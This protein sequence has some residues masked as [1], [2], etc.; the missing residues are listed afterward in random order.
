[1]PRS[2]S[3]KLHSETLMSARRSP[4]H[5]QNPSSGERRKTL[6][7][8]HHALSSHHYHRHIIICASYISS[9]DYN[10]FMVLQRHLKDHLCRKAPK[11]N[12][13]LLLLRVGGFHQLMSFMGAGCKLVEEPGLDGLWVTVYDKNSLSKMMDRTTYTKPFKGMFTDRCCTA[14]ISSTSS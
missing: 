4:R 13:L 7:I 3:I 6:S 2:F 1:M 14:Y 8:T 11:S 12:D 9:I 5:A 10:V